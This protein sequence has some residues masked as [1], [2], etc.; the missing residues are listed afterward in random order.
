MITAVARRR[1]HRVSALSLSAGVAVAAT[2]VYL[3]VSRAL[4]LSRVGTGST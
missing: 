2:A 3:L 4:I 1:Q